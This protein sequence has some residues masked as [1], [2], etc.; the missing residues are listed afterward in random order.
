MLNKKRTTGGN[1]LLRMLMA[2]FLR[3]DLLCKGN[4]QNE[5][6]FILSSFLSFSLRIRL[7][8]FSSRFDC[9]NY[10]IINN[11]SESNF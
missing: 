4:V 11:S 9:S 1:V 10:T 3:I 2:E 8:K 6:C 7:F 5:N